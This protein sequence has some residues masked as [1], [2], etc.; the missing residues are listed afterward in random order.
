MPRRF[1]D[2]LGRM[3][4][5]MRPAEQ[6]AMA[7]AIV[8]LALATT[9]LVHATGGVRFAYLHVMY[10]V[11]VLAAL[12]FGA[13][14]GIAAG[15]AGGLLLGPWMPQDTVTGEMQQTVNWIYRT[16]FF[17]LVGALTGAG[18]QLL[19]RHLRELEWLHEHHADT[20]LLNLTGLMRELARLMRSVVPGE[21]LV[22]SVTQFN[23][24]LE[25]QN[26][27]GAAFGT[28][29]LGLVV[30][31]AQ[32]LLPEGS[33]IALVQPDRLATVVCG[34]D[35][36]R[37]LKGR[38]DAA[39]R[40]S[41]VVDG[42]PI[43]LEAAIGAAHYPTHADRPEDLVQKA[44]IAMHWAA[45]SRTAV[46][47]YDE[48]NDRTS[49]D[50][51]ILL[52]A[53]PDAIGREVLRIWHQAKV[54]LCSG[55]PHGTEAL[56]R[57]AHPDRGLV[58][59]GAF[60]PQLE[61]TS[62]INPVTQWVIGAAL[63]DAASWR[64]AGYPLRVAINLSVRNLG[65]RMLLDVLD[66]QTAANAIEPCD[67]ELEITESAVMADP[68]NCIR[69]VAKLRER[70]YRVAIDDFG[71]GQ[72]SLGYLQKLQVSVLKIDQAFVRTLADDFNNQKI[73]RSIL[74]LAD[75]LGLETVAEGV[76]DMRAADLLRGWGCTYAQGYGFHR[77]APSAELMGWLGTAHA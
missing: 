7:V 12:S 14:G 22:I 24:F 53:L 33:L 25:I 75:S 36:A 61:E 56:L 72:S 35:R 47:V 32:A 4:I 62:L 73:V 18:A 23:N 1:V 42:V 40:E 59:P 38:I 30:D 71:V 16:I 57:W 19:R 63:R 15:L 46:A 3:F 31:R 39:I 10:L 43:H 6:L 60:I 64:V 55:R 58:P 69:L 44:S 26:T 8:A 66:R 41:Y 74:H 11:V 50:N 77:P 45:S 52:G 17:V 27:F 68:D 49:R 21:K 13:A 67:V 65:D 5:R 48:S 70:G 54:E 2:S 51:L 37:E 28:R 20:G 9:W 34:E 29:L 76:E